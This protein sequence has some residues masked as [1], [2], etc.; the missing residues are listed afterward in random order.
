MRYTSATKEGCM[1]KSFCTMAASALLV[2]SCGGG[3]ETTQPGNPIPPASPTLGV[4]PPP[5]K[6]ETLNRTTTILLAASN[7][8]SCK[9]DRTPSNALG[10]DASLP[11]SV[12]VFGC[13]SIVVNQAN[14]PPADFNLNTP[15]IITYL[16]TATGDPRSSNPVVTTTVST[17]LRL[18]SGDFSCADI[19]IPNDTAW[20]SPNPNVILGN[21][22]YA[23]SKSGSFT[24]R[25]VSGTYG[26]TQITTVR[27]PGDTIFH[28]ITFL[29]SNKISWGESPW[30]TLESDEVHGVRIV[31]V[32]TCPFT[33]HLRI[34]H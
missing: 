30:G 21:T 15:S 24:A 10:R 32:G 27:A 1:R 29:S 2:V 26:G 18:N 20:M 17:T 19:V 3:G 11:I 22:L 13:D 33:L 4:I 31:G 14:A 28:D 7:A 8:L 12:K 23:Q 9:V 6:F 34:K 16:I 5:P 25:N